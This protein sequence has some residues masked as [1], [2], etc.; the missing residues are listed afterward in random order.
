MQEG[1]FSAF[2]M[3]AFVA[4][5]TPGPNNLMVMASGTN[6]GLVRTVP[7]ILGIAF[8]F[9][10]MLLLVGTGLMQVFAAFPG[11]Y[12][13]LKAV[14]IAYLLWLAWKIATASA[15]SE[16]GA[17]GRPL[18]FLQAAAFQWVN[19]KAWTI[20]TSAIAA[21][22]PDGDM[23]GILMAAFIFGAM[24]PFITATWTLAGSFIRRLL[25]NPARLALFN[26][27]MAALLL[28]SLLST[29]RS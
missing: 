6:F 28:L 14:S 17:S 4:S 9:A 29:L 7:H 3:F 2:V 13:I 8:G 15:P 19:P 5:A 24:S 16:D 18:G 23:F 10:V 22:V 26:Y 21:F 12:G 11:L 25:S 20:A 1:F 27:T